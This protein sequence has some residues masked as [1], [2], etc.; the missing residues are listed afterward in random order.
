MSSPSFAKASEGAAKTAKAAPTERRL[1]YEMV[2]CEEVREVNFHAPLPRHCTRALDAEGS[3]AG[4]CWRDMR[5]GCYVEN[6]AGK[7]SEPLQAI[8]WAL[9]KRGLGMG[10]SQRPVLV[11]YAERMAARQGAAELQ[12]HRLK[13]GLHYEEGDTV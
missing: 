10:R 12:P 3:V 8:A 2:G 9:W 6:A 5:A 11:N 13:A 7:I 1:A 4:K